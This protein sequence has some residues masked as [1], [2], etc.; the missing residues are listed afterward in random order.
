MATE[1]LLVVR[2]A[3]KARKPHFVR[4]NSWKRKNSRISAPK[5]RR[6]KGLHSKMREKRHGNLKTPSQ[7]YR[8]PRVVRGFDGS[9]M[10]TVLVSSPAQLASVRDGGVVIASGVGMRKRLLII[11]ES[12]KMGLRIIGIDAES[13]VKAAEALLEKRKKAG[14]SVPVGKVAASK[15]ASKAAV[16]GELSEEDKRLQEKKSAEKII[17][18]RV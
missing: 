16:S 9:G 3:L 17:T 8:S 12:L 6:P 2:K 7:G 5:W 4:Q 14:A 18:R 15:A 13:F 11:K 1:H 10:R